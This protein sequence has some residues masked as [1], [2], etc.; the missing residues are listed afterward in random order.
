MI[1]SA[2]FNMSIAWLSY[3]AILPVFRTRLPYR[4]PTLRVVAAVVVLVTLAVG[5]VAGTLAYRLFH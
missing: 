2:I 1:A 5:Q 3:C 4:L